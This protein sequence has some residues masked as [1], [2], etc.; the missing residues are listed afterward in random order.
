MDSPLQASN[1]PDVNQLSIEGADVKITIKDDESTPLH[2]TTEKVTVP[3]I[4]DRADDIRNNFDKTP[5]YSCEQTQTI[6]TLLTVGDNG[7]FRK[8]TNDLFHL[9]SSNGYK[10][11]LDVLFN[12]KANVDFKGEDINTSFRL[13]SSDESKQ[14]VDNTSVIIGDN[15]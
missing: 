12:M 14:A 3:L 15:N 2:T 9:A 13:A 5:S 6:D 11:V 7:G 1:M 10:K 8:D 4:T